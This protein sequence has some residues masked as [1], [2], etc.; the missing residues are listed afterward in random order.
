MEPYLYCKNEIELIGLLVRLVRDHIKANITNVASEKQ[1]LYI[2]VILLRKSSSLF[3][4]LPIFLLYQL[5]KPT[6]PVFVHV[7]MCTYESLYTYSIPFGHFAQI[8]S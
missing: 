6:K 7:T 8:C 5:H 1:A 4:V 2:S 3:C